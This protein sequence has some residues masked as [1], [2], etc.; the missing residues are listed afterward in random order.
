MSNDPVRGLKKREQPLGITDQIKGFYGRFYV[1][2]QKNINLIGVGVVILLLAAI[3]FFGPYVFEEHQLYIFPYLLSVGIVGMF[4]IFP[5]PERLRDNTIWNVLMV[6]L[7]VYL[8]CTMIQIASGLETIPAN[9]DNDPYGISQF[10][11]S[12]V[13]IVGMIA[14]FSAI[15][16]S[17]GF[18]IIILTVALIQPRCLG[19]YTGTH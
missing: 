16:G 1:G 4:L 3:W 14:L 2:P 12:I 18:S 9:I 13:L 8:I 19:I 11:F 10:L 15:S 5:F 17:V 7:C 6:I